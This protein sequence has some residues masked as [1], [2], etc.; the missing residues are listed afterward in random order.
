MGTAKDPAHASESWSIIV[1]ATLAILQLQHLMADESQVLE[2]LRQ[3][4]MVHSCFINNGY[5]L[6]ASIGC[7]LVQH[8]K[9][10]LTGVELSDVR[11]LL[12][13]SLEIW[14]GTGDMSREANK[15]VEALRTV[16]GKHMAHANRTAVSPWT[17]DGRD[18]SN[19]SRN[20]MGALA[21]PDVFEQ[22]QTGPSHFS[23]FLDDLP[24]IMGEV[25]PALPSL[26]MIDYW[27]PLHMGS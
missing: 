27:P 9:D 4:G 8:R 6:A 7:F 20:D 1:E 25:D 15:V 26:P 3:T 17:V 10:R 13:K 22:I 21:V 11:G 19:E 12:G 23:S 14:S 24:S 16:L 5:F 2:T 18:C